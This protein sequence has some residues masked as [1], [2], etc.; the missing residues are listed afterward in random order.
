MNAKSIPV[1][2]A[3]VLAVVLGICGCSDEIVDP[4]EK[5][6][7][8]RLSKARA[9][10]DKVEKLF[11][12]S[13]ELEPGQERD[14]KLKNAYDLA[15]E[16]MDILNQLDDEFSHRVAPPGEVLSH[17]PLMKKLSRILSDMVRVMPVGK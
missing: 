2:V 11:Y 16:A 8:F 6:Y 17:K 3:A 5:T 10:T 1:L 4:P 9:L 12:E 13:M 15:V 7:A 14:S